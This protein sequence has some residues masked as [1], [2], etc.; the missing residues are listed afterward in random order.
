MVTDDNGHR[1]SLDAP[2]RR[3]ITLSPHTTELA[4]QAGAGPF[5]VAVSAYSDH[6]PQAGDLPKLG[7]GAQS[8]M[9]RLLAMQPDLVLV[10]ASGTPR[11][12]QEQLRRLGIAVYVSEPRTLDDIARNIQRIGKLAGTHEQA[13]RVAKEFRQRLAVLS[14]SVTKH[15]PD[16]LPVSV[17]YQVWP[18]PLMTVNGQHVISDIVRRCGGRNVVADFPVLSGHIDE[19]QVLLR[20]P[21]VI[22]A[23]RN[24]DGETPNTQWQRWSHLSA[25]R[26]RQLYEVA[27]DSMH[28]ASARILD[29]MAAVC[30]L[31]AQYQQERLQ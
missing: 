22:I 4:F 21:E 28:R 20:N 7:G 15:A 11:H 6:P 26:N 31:L 5:V 2:A 23:A 13:S 29:G 14:A 24:Y 3:I 30:H 12:H 25:V 19:E 1:V 16:T 17:F 10:W 27:A 9:E 8:D 18:S